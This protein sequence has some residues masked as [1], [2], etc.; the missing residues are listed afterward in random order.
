MGV[1]FRSG[2]KTL[3]LALEYGLASQFIT[4]LGAGEM[5][6]CFDA[7]LNCRIGD[8][9]PSLFAF[10]PQSLPPAV[11][12]RIMLY[13]QDDDGSLRCTLAG[14]DIAFLF[15]FNPAGRTLI[16]MAP[17]PEGHRREAQYRRAIATG[18]PLWYEGHVFIGRRTDMMLTR[19]ALPVQR[20]DGL[21]GI[22]LICFFPD[23]ER[24]NLDTPQHP[25]DFGEAREAWAEP[26]DLRRRA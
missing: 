21:K 23:T 25:I 24:A 15:G 26:E 3:R 1:G 12:P 19:L 10:A 22:L 16:E 6:A 9:L 11:L 8:T 18:L 7:W 17:T 4:A 13:R 5:R 2:A 20:A 14:E